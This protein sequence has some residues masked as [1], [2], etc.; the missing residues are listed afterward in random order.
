MITR[1]SPLGPSIAITR[2]LDSPSHH[3]GVIGLERCRH[4][5]TRTR[6]AR[7]LPAV[8]TAESARHEVDRRPAPARPTARAAHA[9]SA[10]APLHHR[11]PGSR[12]GGSSGAPPIFEGHVPL[13]RGGADRDCGAVRAVSLGCVLAR[14]IPRAQAHAG[15]QWIRSAV[16]VHRPTLLR[17]ESQ[18]LGNADRVPNSRP[19]RSQTIP[20]SSI[21]NEA[22]GLV[23]GPAC[24]RI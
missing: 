2:H 7:Q 19:R 23:R 12:E 22:N 5:E 3:R 20:G 9:H 18:V 15:P 10:A 14:S 13:A 1:E 4:Q 16:G 17:A 21:C 11:A 6:P 24:R 8:P